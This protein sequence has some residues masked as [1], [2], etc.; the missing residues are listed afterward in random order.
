[1]RAAS[2]TTQSCATGDFL[3]VYERPRIGG[4]GSFFGGFRTPGTVH[5]ASPAWPG[6]RNPAHEPTF[7]YFLIISSAMQPDRHRVVMPI[8]VNPRNSYLFEGGVTA[9]A[10]SNSIRK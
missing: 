8:G 5:L 10:N 9:G 1:M 6:I 2:T 7:V 4:A 3:K